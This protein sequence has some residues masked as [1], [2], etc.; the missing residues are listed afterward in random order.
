MRAT[1]AA[2]KIALSA[3]PAQVLPGEPS[4]V[5]RAQTHYVQLATVQPATV[6][7]QISVSFPKLYSEGIIVTAMSA[8]FRDIIFGIVYW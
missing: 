6:S 7:R 3:R 4:S 5:V 2:A 8:L 1:P